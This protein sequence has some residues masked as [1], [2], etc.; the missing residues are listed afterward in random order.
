[1][2]K[3]G[4]HLTKTQQIY[5]LAQEAADALPDMF[6]KKGPGAGNHFTN[7]YMARLNAVVKDTLGRSYIE[8]KICEPTDQC[9]D[10]Y[11][12][13]ESTI[14]EVE[15]SLYNVH[16]NLDRDIFKALLAKDAGHSVSTLL[17]IGKEPAK[18]RHKQPASRALID[19]VK[20]H[21]D[22]TVVIEDIKKKS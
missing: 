13:E 21:H 16:T 10:F 3:G 17:L 2:P 4:F 1:M 9:V 20:K 7:K 18:E 19:F 11:V 6:S 22:L 12:P 14:I 8:Q 5:T 15:L